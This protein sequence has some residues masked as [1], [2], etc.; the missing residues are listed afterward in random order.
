MNLIAKIDS[1]KDMLAY[2]RTVFYLLKN[3]GIRAA[4]NFIFVKLFVL[5]GEGGAG[6][7]L[8]LIEPLIRRLGLIGKITP[9]PYN[10][11][12]EITNKCNKKCILCEHTYWDEPSKDLK[13]DQFKHIVDQFPKLKW[14]NLTGEGDA[15]LNKD[16]LKMIKYL[17]EKDIPVFLVDSFDLINEEI[18]E[19][20]V[21]M[22]VDGIWVS[23]DGATKETYEKIKVGCN[24]EK[25]LNNLKNL[26]E[27]KKE[28]GT[29]IP[30]I[31][32]RYIIT[33]LNI[34]EMPQF[35]E[36]ISSL[37]DKKILGDAS[38]VEFVG[39]LKF[40]EIEEYYVPEVP[41]QLME[42]TLEKGEEL[43][44][45]VSFS[46]P[47]DDLPPIEHCTA[48][49]EPYIMMGGYV[50]PC[51]AVL[52]SNKRPF[53]RKHSFG[54]VFEESF[55]DIWYSERYEKFRQ[56]VPD[57]EEQ[58]PIL[59]KGCRAYETSHREKCY[60]VSEDI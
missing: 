23:M 13:F 14:V 12:I 20:L 15:F 39:L 51:C 54:N 4:Y 27:I 49:M 53:L 56:M 37:G 36:L 5:H 57:P 29:P 11:E 55:K 6:W 30:E 48:W 33:T 46:H 41:D 3:R 9:Y 32:F 28:K 42:E 40:D 17:K 38:R 19:K 31:C 50:L 35:V 16:Y 21:N 7:F 52:M 34:N 59:C 58:V 10:L 18:A 44:V 24:F 47:G 26:L 8:R 2:R 1:I 25:S 60:G 45:D 22:D 43:G